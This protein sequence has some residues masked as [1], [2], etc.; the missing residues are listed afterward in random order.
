MMAAEDQA[1]QCPHIYEMWGEQEARKHLWG[2]ARGAEEEWRQQEL[3]NSHK[4]TGAR[5]EQCYKEMNLA[6]TDVGKNSFRQTEMG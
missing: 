3:V 4:T 6:P 2:G 1:L 5:S